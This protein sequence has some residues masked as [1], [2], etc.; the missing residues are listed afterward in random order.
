MV[1]MRLIVQTLFS[2]VRQLTANKIRAALTMLGIIIGVWAITAVI[3]AVLSLN[4]W[5]LKSFEDFGANKMEVWGQVPPSLRNTGRLS[6]QTVRI[7]PEE[8]QAIREHATVV[9]RIALYANERCTIRAGEVERTGVRITAVEPEWFPINN[10]V[11]LQGRPLVEADSADELQVC[12]VND[13]AIEELRLNDGVV[14]EFITINDRRFQIVGVLQTRELGPMFG[15]DESQSEVIVPFRL[16]YKLDNHPWPQA[17]V[18]MKTGKGI[19]RAVEEVQQE[20]RYILRT[21]RQLKPEDEDTFGMFV[22]ETIVNNMRQI[23]SGMLV[24]AAVL[25][26]ISL[27]VGGV[28]IMNIMLVSVSERTREI[29]LRK[30]IGANPLVILVQ[31]LIEAVLLCLV[32]GMLGVILGQ[33]SVLG[34]SQ[35]DMFKGAEIPAWAIGLAFGFSAGVG[36]V[37]G[38]GPALKAARLNPIEALRHE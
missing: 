3:A 5:V 32:G 14:G 27:L 26:G 11:V 21:K 20:V 25:V 6:W 12:L 7:T 2:A 35:V 19:D 1:F 36:I 18:Q 16:I 23:G 29:G 9:Q 28:G 10:R 13:K 30:A 34:L 17:I 4:T 22:F 24:A 15:G 31:F 37:F 38:M 33:L 8:A